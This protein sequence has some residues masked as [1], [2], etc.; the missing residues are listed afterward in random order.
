M[1]L[2]VKDL[3][4]SYKQENT[5]LQNINLKVS[6]GSIMTILGRNGAGKSTLLN[7][8][9]GSLK[10]TKGNILLNGKNLSQLKYEERAKIIGYVPQTHISTYSYTVRE[11]VVMGRA[12]YIKIYQKPSKEDYIIVDKILDELNILNLSNKLY[13][14]ISGGERQKVT[15]ARVIAQQPDI[16]ILDEPT[17]YLDYGNQLRLITQVKELAKRGFGIIMTTHMPDHVLLLGGQV[18]VID[19]NGNIH[20]GDSERIMTGEILSD[21]YQSKI[22]IVNLEK[23]NR[24]ICVASNW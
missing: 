3:N 9:T 1:I 5:I 12:S 21:L 15:I 20:V 18:G 14:D 8:I 2:E 17:A 13:T 11:F 23:L 6:K 4:F 24:K 22:E 7:C 19:N 10:P 16:I